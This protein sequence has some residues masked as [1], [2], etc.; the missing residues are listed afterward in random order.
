ES[1]TVGELVTDRE[2]GSGFTVKTGKIPREICK[3]FLVERAK[4]QINSLLNEQILADQLSNR[5]I[6]TGKKTAYQS[7]LD[8]RRAIPRF[9]H[10]VEVMVKNYLTKLAYDHGLD[11]SIELGDVYDDVE[12]KIDFVIRRTGHTRGVGVQ[13]DLEVDTL[14]V[15][16]TINTQ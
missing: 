7:L 10:V 5:F 13:Q 1:I 9:G 8:E 14:A 12:N 11:I 16:F 15:Q 6:D 2:W 4:S 3:T